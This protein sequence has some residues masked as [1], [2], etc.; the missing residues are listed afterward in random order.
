MT[1]RSDGTYVFSILEFTS[2]NSADAVVETGTFTTSGSA[3]TFTP[4]QWSCPGPDPIY[5]RHVH[6]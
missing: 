2:P 3:V 5:H 1:F 4:Q 6:V